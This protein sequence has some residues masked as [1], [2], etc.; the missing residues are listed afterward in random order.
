MNTIILYGP[1][2]VSKRVALSKIKKEYTLDSITTVDLKVKDLADLEVALVSTSLFEA[3]KRLVVVENA[4]ESLRLANLNQSDPNLTLVIV[5]GSPKANSTFLSDAKSLQAKLYLFE[6]EK[7]VSA[8][9]FLD[10]LIEGKRGAYVELDKLLK[11]YGGMYVYS[12]IYYLLRRNILPLPQS[13]FARKKITQQKQKYNT[14][15]FIKF[16]QLTLE[17]EFSI[18]KGIMPE[19]LSLTNLVS[20]F[21]QVYL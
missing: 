16:Y 13:D 17:S 14:E 21:I 3:G 8:F 11:E 1:G 18:K 19:D 9:P 10:A 5:A 12:M 6:G 2:E 20:D 4:P 7:E 15:D